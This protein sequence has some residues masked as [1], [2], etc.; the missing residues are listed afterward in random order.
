MMG[1]MVGPM[2]GGGMMG[3][4][5]NPYFPQPF[6]PYMTPPA[7]AGNFSPTGGGS[8]P[9]PG[10]MSPMTN[11]YS[12]GGFGNGAN[13]RMFHDPYGFDQEQTCCVVS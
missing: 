4:G 2:M 8:M 11:P 5:M 13:R 9:L 12:F 3:G 1:G 6:N 7:Y 10:M